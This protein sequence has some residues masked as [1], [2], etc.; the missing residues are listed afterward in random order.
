M[1]LFTIFLEELKKKGKFDKKDYSI[2]WLSDPCPK[3]AVGYGWLDT[4]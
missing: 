3:M 4:I 1:F 2:N